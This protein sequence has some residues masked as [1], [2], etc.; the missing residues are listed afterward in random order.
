[1]YQKRLLL[2]IA[3]ALPVY[4]LS[5]THTPYRD[6]YSRNSGFFELLGTGFS[7]SLKLERRWITN[8]SWQWGI[9]VGIGPGTR[10]LVIPVSATVLYGPESHHLEY[11]AG[12]SFP[13]TAK[14][15]TSPNIIGQ[16]NRPEEVV[17]HGQVGYRYQPKKGGFLFRLMYTP[18][19][20]RGLHREELVDRFAWHHWVGAS[21]GVAIKRK[22]PAPDVEIKRL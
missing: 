17:F 1:M 8:E 12:L 5:Q 14:V 11:G 18:L 3:L 21:L 4:S 7:G 13:F 15:N 6:E 19:I 22:D 16:W 20:G 2:L 10:Q 9:Q